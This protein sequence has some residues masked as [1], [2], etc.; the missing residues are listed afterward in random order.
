HPGLIEEVSELR[1]ALLGSM[2]ERPLAVRYR[3][4]PELA[5]RAMLMTHCLI[6]DLRAHRSL[7]VSFA[8]PR[9]SSSSAKRA[10]TMTIW[11]GAY[12]SLRRILLDLRR[13]RFLHPSR[14]NSMSL[15]VDLDLHGKSAQKVVE[16]SPPLSCGRFTS[17]DRDATRPVSG[18]L[19][20]IGA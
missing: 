6:L 5:H 12:R 4:H 10:L 14:W 2:H 7:M 9:W 18:T 19:T 13:I 17:S 20:G 8:L 11:L 1:Q 3:R 15:H 16:S